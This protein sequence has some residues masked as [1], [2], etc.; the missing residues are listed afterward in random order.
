MN[1]FRGNEAHLPKLEATKARLPHFVEK[2][3]AR[4]KKRFFVNLS[5]TTA[6]F[7]AVKSNNDVTFF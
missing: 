2:P 4:G 7:S 1:S 5:S 3:R 6:N